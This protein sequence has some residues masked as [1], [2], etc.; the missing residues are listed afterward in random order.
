ME[1]KLLYKLK[2]EYYICD[3]CNVG[4]YKKR[5]WEINGGNAWVY[6]CEGC[7]TILYNIVKGNKLKE[8]KRKSDIGKKC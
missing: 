3:S 6:L 8:G 7:I 5:I 4:S 2:D 1:V